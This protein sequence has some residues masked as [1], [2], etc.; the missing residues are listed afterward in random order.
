M[1]VDIPSAV[2]DAARTGVASAMI[3]VNGRFVPADAPHLSALDR[4]FTLADGVFETM[5]MYQGVVFRLEP[6]LRRLRAATAALG[7]PLRG[8]VGATIAT[9]VSA[10]RVAGMREA[11]V[12]VTVSRGIGTTGVTQPPSSEP[13]IV[14]AVAVLPPFAPAIYTDGLTVTV[15]SGRRNE[16]AMTAGLKTL[17]Y[18]DSVLALAE[19][20][21]AGADDALFLDTE[22]H[23]S[24]AT[25]SNVFVAR[26]GELVTP[27]LSCGAL[28]GI[29]R[30]AVVELARKLRLGVDE[31]PID[32]DELFTADELF[33]T[34]SLR[35]VAPV[36]SVD[37]RPVGRAR[38]GPLTARV[39]DEY[40]ALVSR[41]CA[42]EPPR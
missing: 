19:A 14:V 39:M 42:S 37:G 10:A 15:A 34:S 3:W 26:D 33:L 13:T 27:P 24:E 32:R 29:T 30:A 17:A 41:E 35:G 31:R 12:R 23:V 16:R 8:D 38:P 11:S 22:G 4:G 28:P 18:T 7:I 40:A 6:H 5:R 1:S 9:A 2:P 20:R 21:A 25:S 36:I